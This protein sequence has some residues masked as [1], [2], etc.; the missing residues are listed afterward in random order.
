MNRQTS[1]ANRCGD[2]GGGATGMENKSKGTFKGDK[3]RHAWR[4]QK[5]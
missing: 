3:G 5:Q 2:G 1:L 4:R